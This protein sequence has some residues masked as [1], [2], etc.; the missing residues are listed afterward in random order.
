M[1]I[2][3]G[4]LRTPPFRDRLMPDANTRAW[5]DLGQRKPVGVV[6]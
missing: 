5:D 4:R 2:T 6:S 1:S 3:F